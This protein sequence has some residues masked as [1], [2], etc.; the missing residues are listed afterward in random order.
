MFHF[1][2]GGLSKASKIINL[3]EDIFSGFNSTLCGGDITH[4]EYIQ[5]GKG[6]DVGMNQISLFEA[7]VAN[8]NG[9]KT[10]SRDVYRR[11]RRFDFCRML[12]FYFTTIGF[13]FSS[14]VTVLIVYVFLYERLYMVLSGLEKAILQ[15]PSVH[16]SK[17]LEEALATHSVS[18]WFLV[19]CS[20]CVQSIWI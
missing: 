13:Y 11:G 17:A 20:F 4:H 1:T 10:L 18:M 14:M 8:G 16:Q 7:K 12:S 6:C 3:S 15:D 9:E 19:V 5:A 2:R